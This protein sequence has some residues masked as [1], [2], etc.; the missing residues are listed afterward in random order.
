MNRNNEPSSIKEALHVLKIARSKLVYDFKNKEHEVYLPM[1]KYENHPEIMKLAL[2]SYFTSWVNYHFLAWHELYPDKSGKLF[3]QAI[4]S[5][6]SR[7]NLNIGEI[8]K[9]N[10]SF[11]SRLIS[12]KVQQIDSLID[13]GERDNE[14]YNALLLEYEKDKVLFEREIN[15]LKGAL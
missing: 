7:A 13:K 1:F 2:E 12:S 4:K 11:I 15:R 3:Y 10:H 9:Y 6:L 8:D 14:K 5:L